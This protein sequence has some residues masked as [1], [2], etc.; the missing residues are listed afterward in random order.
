MLKIKIKLWNKSKNLHKTCK[1]YNKKSFWKAKKFPRLNQQFNKN[2]NNKIRN[3]NKK[4]LN[5]NKIN[6]NNKILSN[7]NNNNNHHNRKKMNSNQ[8]M[9]ITQIK[10]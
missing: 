8:K 1:S 9:E 7:S 4:V 10:Y 2:N 5:K 6:N 3:N